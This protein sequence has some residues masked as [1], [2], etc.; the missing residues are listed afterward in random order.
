MKHSASKSFF[1]RSRIFITAFLLCGASLFLL[2][3]VTVTKMGD[4]LWKQLGV[5]KQQGN[6]GIYRSFTG[7]YLYYYDAR[8]IKN[9]ALGNRLGVAKELLDYAKQYVKS[10]VFKKEYELERK[11]AR[12]EAPQPKP[13]RTKEQVQKEEIA[14]TE[15]SIKEMEKN[16]K[17]LDAA[18]K[19][20]WSRY[21][22][23][24]R[25]L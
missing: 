17:D 24:L 18:M 14:K 3:F 21:S 20:T 15:K 4:E 23:C 2:S 6:E 13:V 12:P 19:K 8:N 9:I 11:N 25:K 5:N 7:G 22:R 16:M 10:D 1:V